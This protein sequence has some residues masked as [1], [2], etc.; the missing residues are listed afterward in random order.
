MPLN[1]GVRLG[2]Y[3][4]VSPLGAGGMGEVY[5]ARDTR[6]HRTVAIKT[7][8]EHLANDPDR[9]ARFDREARAI[10]K[11]NHPNICALYDVGHDNGV[12][13]LV[14][15][16]IE[17][18]TLAARLKKGA[19]P[20]TQALAI[21]IDVAA[22]LDAAHRTGIIHRDLKP[23]NVILTKGGA[24]L[25]DFGIAREIAGDPLTTSVTRGT[26]TLDGTLLGTPQYMAPEQLE[27][28]DADARADIFAFGAVLYEM[29]SG[30][31]AFPGET[32]TTVIAAVL[33]RE[34]PPLRSDT[35][36]AL[37]RLV[38]KCLMKDPERRWQ[39]SADLLDDLKW[40]GSTPR[41]QRVETPRV[42]VFVLLASAVGM[43]GVAIA[44]FLA[45]GRSRSADPP[46]PVQFQIVESDRMRLMTGAAPSLSPDGRWLVF[47]AESSDGTRRYWVRSIDKT[48]ARPLEGTEGAF[49]PAFWASDSR[50]VFFTQI[51]NAP[52]V[53]LKKIDVLGGLPQQV[54]EIDAALN[55]ATSNSDGVVVFGVNASR[56]LYRIAAGGTKPV[57]LTAFAK[58]ERW[59]VWPQFLPD[60]HHFLYFSASDDTAR[61]GVYVGT[62]DAAPDRQPHTFVLATSQQAFFAPSRTGGGYL[63]FVSGTTLMAQR[64]DPSTFALTGEAFAV[65]EDIE[66]WRPARHAMFS[67]STTGTLAY[68]TGSATHLTLAWFDEHGAQAGTLGEAAQYV[69]PVIS[70][71]GTR[72]AVVVGPRG[73]TDIW[74]ID[75]QQNTRTRLTSDPA[76]DVRPVWSPDGKYIAFGSNRSGDLH[77]YLKAANGSTPERRVGDRAGYPMSWSPD[78]HSLL[79]GD[80]EKNVGD[81]WVLRDPLSEHPT[82]SPLIVTPFEKRGARFSPD[83]HWLSYLSTESGT[84]ELYVT[85][86]VVNGSV[87]SVG[88][89][90]L[91]SKG[92]SVV[93]SAWTSDSRQLIY[94]KR[95]SRG[96]NLDRVAVDT[97]GA[98][99]AP[100]EPF[101]SVPQM[102]TDDGWAYDAKNKRTLVIV[103]PSTGS[104]T[105]RVNWD[106]ADKN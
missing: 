13:Y 37:D 98:I 14:V 53:V 17:G 81:T 79:F 4:I 21:A 39:T 75:I 72:V 83:G 94:E 33:D 70:P 102:L 57:Q 87:A 22:A 7:L 16:Y 106:A 63:L 85:P 24:K 77:T 50:T 48:E 28:R 31:R 59:H 46:V 5:K 54:A 64:F 27:G 11:L 9:R 25:L 100:P 104:F 93:D 65:A 86:F 35:P 40:V 2:P 60:G 32:R 55:G 101:L 71:D 76:G 66:I 97:N 62:I 89:R 74:I 91:V 105:V 96:V 45:F 12:D 51:A 80:A 52:P 95:N 1:A 26:I 49:V 68:R 41:D 3:E 44:A 58:G 6:L 61:S 99:A 42:R 84:W 73:T 38:R 47:P 78:G 82:S 29:L 19:L 30:A 92:G 56:P 20:I 34:P 88:A 69:G 8:R 103:A 10:S 43:A 90:T 23:A 36:P 67:V 15:E 18:Q